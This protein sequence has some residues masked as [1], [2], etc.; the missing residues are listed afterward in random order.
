MRAAIDRKTLHSA[1][2]FVARYAARNAAIPI[3]SHIRIEVLDA[4]M[5]LTASDLDQSARDTIAAKT[6]EHGSFCLPADLLR[7]IIDTAAGDEIEIETDDLSAT[8][9]SEKQ[10]FSIALLPGTDYPALPMLDSE[11]G[12]TFNLDAETLKRVEQEVS[13]AA[14]DPRGRYYLT[15]VSWRT[16]EGS[17]T[18][19]A[20]DTHR[21]SSL[22]IQCR[23]EINIIVPK[24]AMPAWQGDVNVRVSSLFVRLQNGAQVV[25]SK[26][27]EASYPE[28]N[29]I[30]PTNP[31]PL[32]FD[33][34]ELTDAIKRSLLAS[35]TN[36]KSVLLVGRDGVA[37]VSVKSLDRNASDEIRYEG[38][39]FQIAF[40]GALILSVLGSYES[41]MI[42]L[43]YVSHASTV[44]VTDPKDT[45]RK[46]LAFPFHD[47]RLGQYLPQ[48]EA[49]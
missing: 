31:T 46:A 21:F 34:I 5:T 1:V 44:L 15:G 23:E 8:V 9:K 41:E 16:S 26:L 49:A 19:T 37:N 28:T 35:D 24:I 42:Q 18:F 12:Q 39:D 20:T 25:A 40:D 45:A 47:I 29:H 38:D 17:L 22:S 33:R 4:R 7:K 30:F 6:Q 11:E 36:H 2:S 27:I 43:G 32:M 3:L 48:Q 14:E 13:F 10:K